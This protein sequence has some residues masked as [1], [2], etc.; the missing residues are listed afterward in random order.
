[1]TAAIPPT[2]TVEGFLKAVLRSGLFDQPQ[3]DALLPVVPPA[4]RDTA[5]ALA[6]YLVRNG[7][8]SRYQAQKLLKGA[9]I[10]LVLGPYQI[11]A[12][13]GK[14]GMG[15]VYLARDK[16]GDQLT[17]LK[18]L[19]PHKAEGRMLARFQREMEISQ[20]VDH[21]HIALT[22]EV[23][24]Y[25]GAYFIAMEYIPGKNLFHL[26]TDEGPLRTPRAARLFA[27]VA[28]GLDHAHERGLVHRDLKPSNLIVTPHD[29]AKVL[30]LGLAL[31][32]GETV[33]DPAVVGG[34][35]YIVG[36]MDYIA[37]EQTTDPTKVDRRCDVYGLGCTLYFA[38]S[39]KPPFPGGTNADKIHCHRTQEPVPLLHLNSELPPAFVQIVRKMMAKDPARRYATAK[40]VEAD[41]R[42]WAAGEPVQPMD[43]PDDVDFLESVAVLQAAESPTDVSFT[44]LGIVNWKEATADTEEPPAEPG[45]PW[46]K[47]WREKR[48]AWWV[49]ALVAGLGMLLVVELILV[50]YAAA[51][52]GR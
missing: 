45:T 35:G 31:I 18:V 44:N 26:V 2:M 50:V 6:D 37:P 29:H 48:P 42:A 38:V 51:S 8:L 40:A 3:L 41:L 10:G 33:L 5:K 16:R 1:M 22:Y 25:H 43:N 32:Q 20:K 14:G 12:P 23:G 9:A 30:D 21:A 47:K 46:W 36:S 15:V 24:K 52:L 4:Q 34:Q 39:G 17:A 28:S 49:I 27:E 19:A 11:L 13:I 7:W